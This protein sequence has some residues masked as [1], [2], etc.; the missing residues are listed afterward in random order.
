MI[1]L[2]STLF[3]SNYYSRFNNIIAP[4]IKNT[5]ML[6]FIER[7]S[8]KFLLPSYYG[9]VDMIDDIANHPGN[10]NNNN[11]IKVD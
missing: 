5:K 3:Y 9:Q 10:I 7:L 1:S 8:A 11:T 2:S 4:V 6:F